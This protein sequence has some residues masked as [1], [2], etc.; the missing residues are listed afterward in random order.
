[1]LRIAQFLDLY[2]GG[3]RNISYAVNYPEQ[4]STPVTRIL[5]AFSLDFERGPTARECAEKSKAFGFYGKLRLDKHRSIRVRTD[6]VPYRIRRR[7]YRAHS[8]IDSI[9][10]T[11]ISR[12]VRAD[13]WCG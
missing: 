10:R 9:V 5:A 6:S 8:I 13:K 3:H 4:H 2:A 7:V 11:R 1:M 12:R